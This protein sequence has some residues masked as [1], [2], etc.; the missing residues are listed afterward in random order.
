M[1]RGVRKKAKT[2]EEQIAEVEMQIKAL[3]EQKKQLLA[4]KKQEDID[5]LLSAAKE[6]GYTPAELVKKLTLKENMPEETI[7]LIN[8]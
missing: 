8:K 4:E 3:H 5:Q 7:N 6:A 2:K 1:A